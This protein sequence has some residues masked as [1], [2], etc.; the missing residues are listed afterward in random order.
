M[1]KIPNPTYTIFWWKANRK[2][3]PFQAHAKCDQNGEIVWTQ[4][5][6]YGTRAH[7]LHVAGTLFG[8]RWTIREIAPPTPRRKRAA[9]ISDLGEGV[10]P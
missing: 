9:G 8:G 10:L 4:S 5:E 3:Q 2:K 6:G 7:L 1:K